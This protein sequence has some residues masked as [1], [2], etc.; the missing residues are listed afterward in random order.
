M[1]KM[2]ERDALWNTETTAEY[3]GLSPATLQMW[4]YQRRGPPFIRVSRGCVRYKPSAVQK[5]TDDRQ[6]GV[7]WNSHPA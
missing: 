2:S 5:W 4:R 3:L 6:E 1:P 7:S